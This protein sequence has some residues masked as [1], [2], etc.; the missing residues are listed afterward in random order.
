MRWGGTKEG[1]GTGAVERAAEYGE[2][3][4]VVDVGA[5]AEQPPNHEGARHLAAACT[6]RGLSRPHAPRSYLT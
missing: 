4:D 6:A 1:G 3:E 5:A 2:R